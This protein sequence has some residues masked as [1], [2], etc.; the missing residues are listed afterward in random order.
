MGYQP[1]GSL[2]PSEDLG[3][4]RQQTTVNRISPAP[5]ERGLS[6]SSLEPDSSSGR[7]ASPTR[8]ET[9]RKKDDE[10][11]RRSTAKGNS[12]KKADEGAKKKSGDSRQREAH[13]AKDK[14][15]KG[16]YTRP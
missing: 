15:K 7:S 10:K 9:K 14:A 2:S 6:I 13:R 5:G 16:R 3:L 11:A 12:K 4:Y 1:Q 8:A